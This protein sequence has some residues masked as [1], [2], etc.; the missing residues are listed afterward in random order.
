MFYTYRRGGLYCTTDAVIPD[1]E[2]HWD[3]RFEVT[4]EEAVAIEEGA[5][6][7]VHDGELIVI[8]ES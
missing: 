3:E 4:P 7:E 8:E 2:Q 6:L 5:N 1:W